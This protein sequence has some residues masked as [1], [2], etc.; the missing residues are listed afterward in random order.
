MLGLS[1]DLVE[2]TLPIKLEFRPYRQPARNYSPEL[3]DRI[4][5]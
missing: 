4:K 5:D 2:H 1:R 3:M